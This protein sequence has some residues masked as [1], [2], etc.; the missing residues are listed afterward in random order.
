VS[1]VVVLVLDEPD[2]DALLS[3]VVVVVDEPEGDVVVVELLLVVADGRLLLV[4]DAGGV[5]DGA[6]AGAGF[7]VSLPQPARA[8]AANTAAIIMRFIFFPRLFL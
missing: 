2:G 1:V 6:G 3:V 5:T 7:G 8:S 4:V